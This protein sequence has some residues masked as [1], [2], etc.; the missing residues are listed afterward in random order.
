METSIL[1]ADSVAQSRGACLRSMQSASWVCASQLGSDR[2]AMLSELLRPK[3]CYVIRLR[4]ARI[5]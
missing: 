2:F 5:Y 1:A 3:S 4:C